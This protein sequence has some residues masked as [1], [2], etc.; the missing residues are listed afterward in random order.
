ME[1][2]RETYESVYLDYLEGRLN[3]EETLAFQAFL[4]AHPDLIVDDKLLLS[5]PTATGQLNQADKLLLQHLNPNKLPVNEETVERL[6]LENLE[7]Q[8]DSDQRERLSSFCTEYPHAKNLLKR[9]E[10][11]VLKPIQVT[12]PN[13]RLLKRFTFEPKHLW[14]P[15]AAASLT[16][17][18]WLSQVNQPTDILPAM[19]SPAIQAR[20][21]NTSKPIKTNQR[22]Q[23]KHEEIRY[24]K[25]NIKQ[26][27]GTERKI[28][29]IDPVPT[30][31]EETVQP[32]EE[33]VLLPNQI[34]EIQQLLPTDIAQTTFLY[35][36]QSA[37]ED[38]TVIRLQFFTKRLSNWLKRPVEIKSSPSDITAGKVWYVRIGKF[39]FERKHG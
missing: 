22:F 10:Q 24:K 16:V 33:T 14:I 11:T 8:L 28:E 15:A 7:G 26:S 39:E 36:Q 30:V 34:D 38:N 29:Q 37:V 5:L 1:I 23:Q 9:Y 3:S 27:I 13:K 35:D 20:Q 2:T 6:I 32:H 17:M 31:Y 25:G 21:Q 4:T 19:Q 12:F 18:L